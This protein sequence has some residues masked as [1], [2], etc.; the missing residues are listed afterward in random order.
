[1]RYEYQGYSRA[2]QKVSGVVEAQDE[3]EAR[4]KLRAMQVRPDL[5]RVERKNPFKS[6]KINT[7]FGSPVKLKQLIVFTRQFSS[8]I[9][10]GVSVVQA[11]DLLEQQ[12]SNKT[13]KKILETVKTGIESGGTLSAGLEKYPHVFGEFFIRVVEAGE[14][15]GT[16]DKSLKSI[17]IQLEKLAKLKSKVIKALT[18]PALTLVASILAVIFLLLKVIPEISKLYGSSKL[19][20][21]TVFVLDISKNVQN[22]IGMILAVA[23]AL[24]MGFTFLYRIPSF[25][26]FWDPLVLKIP[27]FGTLAVRS[28]VSRF[29]TTL[30]TL[31]SSGVP[32]L[33]GFEICAKVISNRALQKSIKRASLG[34]SEGKSIVDGLSVSGHFPPMVIHMIGIG[35]MTGRLDELLS[36][37]AEIYDDEVDNAVDAITS[38]LQPLLIM[39]VGGI[40]LFLMIAMYMPIFSLGD[41]MSAG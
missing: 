10:S 23:F 17:G 1:M 34:V 29:S 18:Y 4:V 6:F 14:I 31:V 8:L 11:L 38:L 37:V 13:F 24:P 22:N 21:I 2:K 9:D 27:L 5:I 35:E 19:P 26:E 36:K 28:S 30:A 25:R 32:L 12:E 40:I 7:S 41:K 39:G 3:V 33:T 20:E 16:L 15:S